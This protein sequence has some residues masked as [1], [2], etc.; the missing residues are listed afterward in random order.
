MLEK[1]LGFYRENELR[2]KREF[3]KQ[4]CNKVDISDNQGIKV[5]V[6]AYGFKMESFSKVAIIRLLK[7]PEVPENI[8]KML[9]LKTEYNMASVKKLESFNQCICSD[10]RVRGAF[11]NY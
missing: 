2:L 5:Y 11:M 7:N 8:K 10:N 1:C 3:L 4:S 6:E 9:K